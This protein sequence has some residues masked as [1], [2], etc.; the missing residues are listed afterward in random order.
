LQSIDHS[1][2]KA[3]L[4]TT[5][6]ITRP[7]ADSVLAFAMQNNPDYLLEKANLLYSRNSLDY[8]RAL[9]KPDVTVGV[10]YDK[11]NSYVPNYYGLTLALPLPFIN[12]NQGNIASA[13]FTVKQQ[14]TLVN[15][16]GFKLTN[17]INNALNKLQLNLDL[18]KSIDPDFIRKYDLLMQNA[19]NAYL[20]RQMNL[21]D[22]LDLFEAYKNTQLKYLQQQ[23][24][25][26]TAKED[27]NLLA[28][29]DV[30]K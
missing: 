25:L 2:V 6:D 4:P 13:A 3:I 29:R 24:N 18:Q 23:F 22:F 21:L 11:V 17:D 12:R 30:I 14:E 9:R 1:F 5:I 28:G 8:Q 15:Q 7:A 26:Q 16:R 19:F 10:E 27:I 20:Q